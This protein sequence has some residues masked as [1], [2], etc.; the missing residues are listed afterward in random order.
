MFKATLKTGTRFININGM[1]KQTAVVTDDYNRIKNKPKINSVELIG[2]KTSR[3][4]N[5]PDYKEF[6]KESERIP[7]PMTAQEILDI[8]K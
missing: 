4:L 8:C 6:I 3:E 7:S 1:S 5:L 2:D